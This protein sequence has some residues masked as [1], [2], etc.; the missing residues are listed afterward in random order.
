MEKLTF[1][2]FKNKVIDKDG[3]VLLG[4]GG[5][6]NEWING[7]GTEFNEDSIT[8]IK[9]LDI[10]F[11]ERYVLTTSGGRIDLALVVDFNVV[12]TGKLAMW[13]I[14]FGDC[15]WINDYIYNYANQY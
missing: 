4:C 5:D 7:V 15:S 13:R 14:R 2:D 9:D 8:E 3:I 1:E 10:L 12:N 6:L 11:P